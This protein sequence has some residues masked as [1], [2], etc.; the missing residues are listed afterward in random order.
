MTRSDIRDLI[1]IERLDAR[2]LHPLHCLYAGQTAPQPA[3]V[4]I[5]CQAARIR[6]G[7][8]PDIG[9]AVPFDVWHGHLQRC[10]ISPDLTAAEIND[11]MARIAPLAARVVV[12]YRSIWNGSN[13]V[14]RFSDDASEAIDEI[15]T[16]CGE[17][18]SSS[19]GV[20]DA[21][22]WLDQS[23]PDEYGVDAETTDE[24]LA[25]IA[26]RIERDARS[27]LVTIEGTID[28]LRAWR[29]ES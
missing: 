21:G 28:V 6:A 19:G 20:W 10:P 26:E 7:Y 8:N 29:R 2:T 1:T 18:E 5:D 17:I 23:T 14:A 25:E 12:D 3:Y 13:H 4:E 15:N 24:R 11:L 22:D 9:G 16:V 27:E